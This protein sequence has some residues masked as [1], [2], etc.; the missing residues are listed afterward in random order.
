MGK[1]VN[2]P[3]WKLFWEWAR[4]HG[5]DSEYDCD[6]ELWW[7]CFLAGAL[8]VTAVEPEEETGGAS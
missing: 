8:A 2:H 3:Y 6:W 4:E 1:P 5:C 7:D